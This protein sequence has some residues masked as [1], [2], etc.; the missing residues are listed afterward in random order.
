MTLSPFRHD[1]PAPRPMRRRCGATSAFGTGAR[2]PLVHLD[3]ANT[4]QKPRVALDAMDDH[5]RHAK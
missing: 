5:H 2:K 1:D 3:S 4:S